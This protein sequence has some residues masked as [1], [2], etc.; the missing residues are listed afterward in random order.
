MDLMIGAVQWVILATD[1]L[2]FL[3]WV[4]LG[5]GLGWACRYPHWRAAFAHIAR[6]QAGMAAATVLMVFAA[7]A[8]L[9]S[10]HYRERIDEGTGRTPVMSVDIRS[11]LDDLL[12]P[13]RENTEKT[14]S[15]PLATHLYAKETDA[16]GY[17]DYPRLRYGGAHLLDR[18]DK[19]DTDSAHRADL[20]LRIVVGVGCGLVGGLI[21]CMGLGLLC[22]RHCPHLAW[23]AVGAVLTVFAVLLGLA[24]A[25]G[26]HYHPL[27]TDKVGQDVLVLALKSVRTGLLI[28]TLTT[29]I[30]L[31]A[32]VVLGLLAGYCGGW[33]D[34]VIQYGYTVLNSIPSVLL[35]AA[36][37]LMLQVAIDAHPDAFT[38]NAQHADARLLAL[39][40]ILGLTSWTGLCRL[41]RGEALKLREMDYVSAARAF[42]VSTPAIMLRHLLP[43]LMHIVLIALVMDFSA[44]VLAEAVLSYV[45]VGVDPATHS[46]GSMINDARMELAREPM[47]WW[48]LVSAFTFMFV[49]VLAANIFADVV[50]EALDP[51]KTKR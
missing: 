32:A 49:L 16:Q 8:L 18:A 38:S 15:A 48:P 51:R 7:I 2:F 10:V 26:Q 41:I 29:L 3:L 9:D 4:L 14:Y 12:R 25:L 31:P 30:M 19:E 22:R 39:C 21:F 40:A 45:G 44:L 35:I 43:N 33:V 34:D 5:C 17:R 28:G 1:A 46:F 23:S 50:R 27:G 42:G 47:V 13:L 24:V 36:S 20:R 11:V 6:S 37:V